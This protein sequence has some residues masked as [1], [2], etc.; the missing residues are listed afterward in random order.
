MGV[1]VQQLVVWW[2]C[3]GTK[4]RLAV[5]VVSIN[6]YCPVI[7]G[8]HIVGAMDWLVPYGRGC[9]ETSVLVFP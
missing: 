1:V 6:N 5:S 7:I 8:V 3:S 9:S 2:W 4:P